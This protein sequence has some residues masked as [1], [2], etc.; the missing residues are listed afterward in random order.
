[1]TVNTVAELV[2][3]A[4]VHP[5]KLNYGAA[6]DTLAQLSGALFKLATGADIVFVPYKGGAAG[7][8]DVLGGQVDLFF[9]ATSI[10]TPF[11]RAGKLKALGMTGEE[12]V[13]QLPEIPTLRESGYE[14]VSY[15]WTGGAGAARHASGGRRKT[16]R[17]D[18][19]SAGGAGAT[20]R[21]PQPLRPAQG[22][23]ARGPR[24]ADLRRGLE[25]GVRG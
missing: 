3:Y 24:D 16:E 8:T 5:G 9:I 23:H 6:T 17:R 7:L 25:M 10:V 14:V 12:R 15:F 4:K 22:R 20:R 19:Q 11:I 21:H 2:A 18:Q 1:V 13:P